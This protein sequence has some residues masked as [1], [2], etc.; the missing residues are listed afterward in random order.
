MSKITY[1]G[2]KLKVNTE[3]N[4]VGDTGIEVLKYLP[5]EDKIDLINICLQS[6]KE[7]AIFNQVKLDAYFHIY[8]VMMY[9]NLN[10]TE[11]KKEEPLKLYDTLQSNGLLNQ[12][13]A[14]IDEEEYNNLVQFLNHQMEDVYTYKNTIG[15]IVSEIIEQLP[16]RADDLAKIMQRF[17]PEKFKSVIDFAKAANGGRP[18]K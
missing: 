3:T 16:A 10:F 5:V 1:T 7:G 12:I 9:S 13:I 15:G 14:A 2:L 6:A 8:L 18:I 17:D 4:P 11:K